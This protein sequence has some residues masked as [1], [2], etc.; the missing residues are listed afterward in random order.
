LHL[1]KCFE[2]LGYKEGD[3]PASE[4]ASKEVLSLPMFP[5]LEENKQVE[6]VKKIKEFLER[7]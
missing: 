2:N 4:R 5:E 1:Q 6:V 3:F 7:K